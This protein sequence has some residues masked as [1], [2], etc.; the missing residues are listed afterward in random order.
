MG[1]DKVRILY[2]FCFSPGNRLKLKIFY[3]PQNEN[4]ALE[5]R[6]T[7]MQSWQEGSPEKVLTGQR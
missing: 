1:F 2:L 5:V 6:A 7:F 4:I 3:I